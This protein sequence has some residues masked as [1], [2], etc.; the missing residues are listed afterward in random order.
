[1]PRDV[2]T[3]WNSTYDMLTFAY[4]Y[5]DALNNITAMR[6]MKL[7]NYEIEPEEW[8]SIKQLRDLLKV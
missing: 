7:R 2:R 8:D 6:E 1:M 5:K 4:E 3:R